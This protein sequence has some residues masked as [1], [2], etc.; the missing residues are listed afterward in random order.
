MN[1]ITA[2][3]LT[4]NDLPEEWAKYHKEVLLKSLNGAPLIVM[5]QKEMEPWGGNVTHVLQDAPKSFSNIYRQLLRGA[6]MATTDYIAVV[7]ADTLYPPEHFLQ[8]PRKGKIGYNMN[9]WHLF[10][11]DKKPIYSWRNRRGNYSMLSDRLYVIDA[12]EE[13]F[14]KW[15]DGTPDRMTGEIGRPMVEHNLNISVREVE[16]FETTVAVVNF[17]HPFG[18]DEMQQNERK[19]AGL[20]RAY[21][22]PYWGRAEDLVKNFK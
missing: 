1:E 8:R 22:V 9:F 11:W 13:R 21:D 15:K 2:I 14:A 6:K 16:E 12:L 3:F 18:S 20:V 4:C 17:Q 10:T 5:S 19:R 7:E